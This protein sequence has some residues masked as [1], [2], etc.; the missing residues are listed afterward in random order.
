MA[1][2][3]RQMS[4]DRSVP[5][6]GRQLLKALSFQVLMSFMLFILDSLPIN[7]FQVFNVL[8]N[9]FLSLCRWS[10]QFYISVHNR[11][12]TVRTL[13]V[14]IPALH[15]SSGNI[16]NH[17][18]SRTIVCYLLSALVACVIRWLV[19]IDTS[20]ISVCCPLWGSPCADCKCCNLWLT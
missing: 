1:L 12:P 4:G 20:A 3:V 9:V 18:W 14:R 19:I 7:Y 13:Y 16:M 8:L 5:Q 11:Q 10:W 15:S 2:S 6:M 17:L